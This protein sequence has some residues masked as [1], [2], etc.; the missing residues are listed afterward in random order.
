MLKLA[1][2]FRMACAAAIVGGTLIA[3]HGAASAGAGAYGVAGTATVKDRTLVQGAATYAA[4][5]AGWVMMKAALDDAALKKVRTCLKAGDNPWPCVEPLAIKV[6]FD[7]LIVMQA[8]VDKV[9]AGTIVITAHVL[10]AQVEGVLVDRAYCEACNPAKLEEQIQNLATR[11]IRALMAQK[12]DTKIEVVSSPSSAVVKIDGAMVGETDATFRTYPGK[13]TVMVARAGFVNEVRD[14]MVAEGK[15]ERVDVVLRNENGKPGDPI[16]AVTTPTNDP[17]RSRGDRIH[18]STVVESKSNEHRSKLMPSML[19]GGGAV[20]LVLGGV[21]VFTNES[22]PPLGQPQPERLD[23]NI[24]LGIGF[25]IAGAAAVGV[26]VYLWTRPDAG[27][28]H[29]PVAMPLQ[30]G[31]ILGWAGT[32]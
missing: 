30:H 29:G 15:T 7:R 23:G 21:L 26:G 18:P 24:P 20:A 16:V 22:A 11:Q 2:I 1:S 17:R 19:M 31:G 6:G 8:D 4:G 10:A 12:G 28:S 9:N 13:H 14:V 3:G 32:L 27:R 25:G 5:E